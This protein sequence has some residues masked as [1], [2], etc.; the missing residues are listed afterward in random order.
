MNKTIIS[1]PH[2]EQVN[3][4]LLGVLIVKDD[5]NNIINTLFY[6]F[7]EESETYVFFKTMYEMISNI[8]Y[9]N[10]VERSYMK[11]DIFDNYFDNNVDGNFTDRLEWFT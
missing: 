7:N 4:K 8:F 11:E 5:N 6:I 9:G 10:N 1:T 2:E 3:D